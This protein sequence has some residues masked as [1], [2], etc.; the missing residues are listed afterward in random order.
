MIDWS[1]RCVLIVNVTLLYDDN[2]L[3]VEKD[4]QDKYLDE[5]VDMWY[6][7][8]AITASIVVSVN[9]LIAN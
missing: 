7:D 1:E 5:F 9:G 4:K 2:L 3:E 8:S 6:V